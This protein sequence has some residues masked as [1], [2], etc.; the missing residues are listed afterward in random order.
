V[1]FIRLLA[2]HP[3]DRRNGRARV[4]LDAATGW[5]R[6]AGAADIY[7]GGE[8]PFYLW[9]GVDVRAADAVSFFEAAGYARLG[10]EMNMTCAADHRADPP[11]GVEVR[12]VIEGAPVLAFVGR[13]WP[14]WRAE[15]ERAVGLGTCFAATDAA[16]NVVGF[17]GHSVNRAGWLGPIGTDPARQHGGV[18]SALVAAVCADARDAGRDSVEIAWVGPVGFYVK[19][20]GAVVSRTFLRMRS[21]ISR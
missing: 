13:H 19:A 20:V 16:G 18:G 15:A 6:D 8:A 17:I 11:T 1:G 2:V 21:R 14:N 5:L 10:A 12:R 4:L 9:P 3:E 7:T